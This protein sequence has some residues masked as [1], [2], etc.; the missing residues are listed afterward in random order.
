MEEIY[1]HSC[2]VCH[3]DVFLNLALAIGR[4]SIFLFLGTFHAH[5]FEVQESA[6]VKEGFTGALLCLKNSSSANSVEVTWLQRPSTPAGQ[7]S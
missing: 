6:G 1:P 4:L 2:L 7:P 5:G 3:V